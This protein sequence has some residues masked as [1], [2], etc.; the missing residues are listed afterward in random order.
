MLWKNAEGYADDTAG[1][2]I[3]NVLRHERRER[4]AMAR[5]NRKT[6]NDYKIRER[7]VKIRKMTDQQLV[8]YVDNS[9]EKARSEGRNEARKDGS[10]KKFLASISVPGVVP[11]IGV[12]TVDKIKKFAEEGGFFG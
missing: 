12:I 8:E 3:T 11:G 10:L 1:S 7:A 5:R 4:K 6:G 2:A 9:V